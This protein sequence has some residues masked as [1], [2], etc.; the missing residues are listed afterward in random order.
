M[1]VAA[2]FVTSYKAGDGCRLKAGIDGYMGQL[3]HTD[4]L[5]VAREL[6]V[7]RTMIEDLLHAGEVCV[8]CLPYW[9]GVIPDLRPSHLYA[10]WAWAKYLGNWEAVAELLDECAAEG[11]TAR[12]VAAACEL[13]FGPRPNAREWLAQDRVPG[14]IRKTIDNLWSLVERAKIDNPA[15]IEARGYLDKLAKLLG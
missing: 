13:A 10:A 11:V 2:D 6:H 15:R 5:T 7:D 4:T 14:E 1:T 3:S 9:R 8:K 12:D